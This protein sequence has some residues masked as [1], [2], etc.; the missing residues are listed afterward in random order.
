MTL[1]LVNGRVL[2]DNGFQ[3]GLDV[4]V[5]DGVVTEMAMT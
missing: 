1:A 3:S 4:M 2:T 5:D